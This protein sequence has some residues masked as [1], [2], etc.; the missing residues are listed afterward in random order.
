MGKIVYKRVKITFSS[1]NIKPSGSVAL[2]S[3]EEVD[4]EWL[5][6]A[7]CDPIIADVRTSNRL[8]IKIGCGGGEI[9]K[10]F[11]DTTLILLSS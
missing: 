3:E 11:S 2:P 1:I 10:G 6:N 5:L 4:S 8:V 9:K 7:Y